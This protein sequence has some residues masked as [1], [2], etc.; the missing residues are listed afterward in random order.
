M[1]GHSLIDS[2]VKS[3]DGIDN[4][5]VYIVLIECV[6]MRAM[7]HRLLPALYFISTLDIISANWIRLESYTESLQALEHFD[8]FKAGIDMMDM[9]KKEEKKHKNGILLKV[10]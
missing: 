6:T 10:S 3:N 5:P 4:L 8:L 2:I 7:E 1:I 9:P